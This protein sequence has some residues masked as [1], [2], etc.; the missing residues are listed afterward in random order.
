MTSLPDA[1][2]R[3]GI[4]YDPSTNGASLRRIMC[5]TATSRNKIRANKS[6]LYFPYLL[7]SISPT[8]P[9]VPLTGNPRMETFPALA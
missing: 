2:A 4:E 3:T 5:P 6:T 1:P 7:A 9:F 8:R